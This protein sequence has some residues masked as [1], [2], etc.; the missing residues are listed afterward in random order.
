M[1]TRAQ[2][3]EAVTSLMLLRRDAVT[4]AEDLAEV[5]LTDPLTSELDVARAAEIADRLRAAEHLIRAALSSL[6][7]QA[8]SDAAIVR[9]AL[10]ND[11]VATLQAELAV[12]TAE[13][14]DVKAAP[15]G[16]PV[17]GTDVP[18]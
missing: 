6:D 17:D 14:A 18:P 9:E 8:R 3:V 2:L 11:R 1:I 7:Q 10:K 5:A 12:L 16:A 15:K 4:V 13:L